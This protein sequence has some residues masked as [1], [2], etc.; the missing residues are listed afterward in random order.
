MCMRGSRPDP[1][2]QPAGGA[3]RHP[4]LHAVASPDRQ[5]R[6][7]ARALVRRADQP[8]RRDRIRSLLA[9]L[10]RGLQLPVLLDDGAGHDQLLSHQVALALQLAVLVGR[11]P[12][13]ARARGESLDGRGHLMER[14]CQRRRCVES[15]ALE[16]LEGAWRGDR[17]GQQDEPYRQARDGR[18]EAEEQPVLR[19]SGPARA[20]R[21]HRLT[22]PQAVCR[23]P[24]NCSSSSAR[25]VPS[26]TQVS[27]S[28]ATVTGRP[29][30]S[31][32]TSS[33]P[34]S[35]APPPVRTMP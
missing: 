6:E 7:A 9:K 19:A 22:H 34:W 21:R 10:E 23:T 26:A 17:E 28:S 11:V 31:R 24:R 13:I 35:K 27:G 12:I 33:R 18:N 8:S 29:V 4:D 25:P 14:D 5:D 15:E 30:S 2:D 20:R 32:S 16:V 3:H 1:A